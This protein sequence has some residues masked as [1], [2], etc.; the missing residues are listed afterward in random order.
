MCPLRFINLTLLVLN[1]WYHFSDKRST[2]EGLLPSELTRG[3]MAARASQTLGLMSELCVQA[4]KSISEWGA[5]TIRDVKSIPLFG[6]NRR[7]TVLAN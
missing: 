2:G 4:G 7:Y 1:I 5:N 3:P 6:G